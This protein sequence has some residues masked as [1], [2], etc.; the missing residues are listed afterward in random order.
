MKFTRSLLVTLL[1]GSSFAQVKPE[2]VATYA[3]IVYASYADALETA[4]TL[5]RAVAAFLAAPDEATLDAAKD[6]WLAAR[7]P[8]GQTEVYRFY[9][10][11]IDGADGLEGLINAWPVDE[12]YIDYVEGAPDAGIVN[13][14]ADYPEITKDLLASLNEVGAEENI[15]T[16]YHAI[17]FL[18][19]GQDLSAAT[20]GQR[21][22]TD[23]TTAPHAR[24]RAAYLSA[25]TELLVEHLGELVQAW[26]PEQSG[27]YREGFLALEPDAALQNVLT[28]MGVLAKSELAG[29][30]I[31][32]AFDNQDQEDEHSCFSDNTHR[33]IIANLTGIQ[34]VYLGRYR[35]VDGSVV[36]G[37]GLN[38]V[39]AEVN[40]E[41]NEEVTAL[42]SAAD[43]QTQAIP[44]PFDQAILSD[45]ARPQIFDL[46]T[47][48]L[49]LGD[50]LAEVGTALGDN[51][52]V[53]VGAGVSSASP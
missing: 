53:G 33:D 43:A 12:V 35:R 40:A 29:D 18:L 21:P 9:G 19:W 17:E 48:L 39:V 44:A 45:D 50:K 26:S 6:A 38:A 49:D 5:Q 13:N 30:R 27:N 16:G 37:T 47:T 22:H 46:V 3:D 23:Y 4:E 25:A 36:E 8:Y 15:A 51:V 10:G 14:V 42:L 34:N 7:E 20:A 32:T 28:G 24:R 11:P 2:A 52:G 1:F 31:F 41:L